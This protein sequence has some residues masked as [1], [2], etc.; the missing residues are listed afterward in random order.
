M[1]LV[2]IIFFFFHCDFRMSSWDYFI[3]TAVLYTLCWLYAQCKTWFEHG[4]RHKARLVAES[5]HTIRISIDTDMT[6]APGQHIFLRFLT[7]G[8]HALTAHPF[9]IC[10]VP[11]Q[12]KNQLMFYVKQRG[13]LTS[14]LMSLARKTPNIQIPVLL[15]G[16]YGG[17]PAGRLDDFDKSLV[18]GGGA[19]AGLTLSMVEDFVRFSP[20]Q[21]SKKELKVIVAT[22]DPGMRAWYTQALDDIAARQSRHEVVPGLS[23]HIHETFTPTIA[24]P[25]T[26]TTE[27]VIE[28]V[29]KT[30]S[31]HSKECNTSTATTFGV[32]VFTG[33]PG[34]PTIVRQMADEDGV[35]LGVVVCGPSTMAFDVKQAASEVQSKILT[36]KP[37][38][39]R[40]LWLHSENFS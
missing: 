31:V 18:V 34:L 3:A 36:G 2:F 17:I 33:R 6:W 27:A 7:C 12:G 13:G 4:I 29:T 20:F 28:E 25:D 30:Q 1:A 15:D 14:R 26:N 39:A 10:S 11:Q 16:P 8:I 19:G 9:T 22:R 21:D 40:E 5:D 37:G 35:S 23:V 32:Q 38:I 24:S